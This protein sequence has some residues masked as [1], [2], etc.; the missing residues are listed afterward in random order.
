VKKIAHISDLHFG[1]VV[2]EIAESLKLLLHAERPDLVIISGDLTQRARSGQYKDAKEYLD[3][4]PQPQ[5]VVPGNHDVPLFN[6]FA[7]FL[8]PLAGY[9]RYISDDLDPVYEDDDLVVLGLNTA[10]SFTW[11]NGRVSPEQISYIKQRICGAKERKVT[12]L[13][14][15]HP[16]L[17]PPEQ[18]KGAVVGRARELLKA[19]DECDLDLMLAGHFHQSYSGGTSEAYT[20]L[21]NS[22]LVVQAGTATSHRTKDERNS[23]NMIETEEGFVRVSIRTWNGAAFEEERVEVYREDGNHWERE[24]HK[25]IRDTTEEA[26]NQSI[27]SR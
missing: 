5:L 18:G 21:E 22:T 20:L 9:K 8:A 14:T 16:F 12:I 15:H 24:D 26:E 4:L 6:V 27:T 19:I 17:P 2:P 23:F 25:P 11:K 1:T 3:S 13:V 7:R 10:R